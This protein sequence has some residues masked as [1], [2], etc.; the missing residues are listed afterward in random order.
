V[1]RAAVA[2]VSDT[3][4]LRIKS[5]QS[6]GAPLG[7]VVRPSAHAGASRDCFA[8][9]KAWRRKALVAFLDGS[10]KR[11]ALSEL[12]VFRC[13]TA[14]TRDKKKPTQYS[15]K[16]GAFHDWATLNLAKRRLC[17]ALGTS[18]GC[19]APC[20]AI[21]IARA[22]AAITASIPRS[23]RPLARRANFGAAKSCSLVI[24]MIAPRRPKAHTVTDSRPS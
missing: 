5:T 10:P 11:N 23:N 13:F 1:E 19:A 2:Q 16:V 20:C 22:R 9:V 14:G 6:T 21:S 24:F 7:T 12:L 3:R 18:R 17:D 15:A 8:S 4:N